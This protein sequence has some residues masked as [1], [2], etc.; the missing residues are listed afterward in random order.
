MEVSTCGCTLI[1]ILGYLRAGEWSGGGRIWGSIRVGRNDGG[2][3]E[4]GVGGGG[5]AGDNGDEDGLL[6][7]GIQCSQCGS[8]GTLFRSGKWSPRCRCSLRPRIQRCVLFIHSFTTLAI[9][10]ILLGVPGLLVH[11][12]WIPSP[13]CLL[14]SHWE[15]GNVCCNGLYVPPWFWRKVLLF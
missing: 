3:G 8:H 13:K 15:C 6:S 10:P 5:S 4:G 7:F 1:I 2:G 12:L 14:Y 11:F 9:L